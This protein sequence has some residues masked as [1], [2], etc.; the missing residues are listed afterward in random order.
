MKAEFETS[1]RSPCESTFPAR[2]H[3]RFCRHHRTCRVKE[4]QMI[5]AHFG[6]PVVF[7]VAEP[8][9]HI[10]ELVAGPGVA[11]LPEPDCHDAPS[12]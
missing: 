9:K 5:Y 7:T 2:S 4:I 11:G 12:E 3:R 8:F 10:L 6:P 1:H